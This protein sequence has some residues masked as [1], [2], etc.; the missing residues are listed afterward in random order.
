MV[1]GFTPIIGLAVVVALALAAVFGSM[2]LANPAQAAVGQPADAELTERVDSPQVVPASFTVS[3]VTGGATLSWTAAAATPAPTAWV[4][5]ITPGGGQTTA[6][7]VTSRVE[8]TPDTLGVFSG[9]LT[10]GTDL[11]TSTGASIGGLTNE[12][13]YCFTVQLVTASGSSA[14]T[15]SMCVTPGAMPGGT[16]TITAV[17]PG[18]GQVE[19]SWT[20]STPSGPAV[21][22]WQYGQRAN[23]ET[24]FSWKDLGDVELDGTTYKATVTGLMASGTTA[25]DFAVRPVSARGVAGAE[26][27]STGLA[28]GASGYT[29]TVGPTFEAQSQKPG[30]NTRYDITIPISLDTAATP[31]ETFSTVTDEIVVELEDYSVPP[32]IAETAV[33]VT[34]TRGEGAATACTDAATSCSTTTIV[35]SL[36]V[37]GEK[38]AITIGDWNKDRTGGNQASYTAVKDDDNITIVLKQSA[39]IKNPTKAGNYGPAIEVKATNDPSNK[40]VDIDMTDRH[41]IQRIVKLSEEDG[42]LGDTVMATASGFEKNVTVRFFIDGYDGRVPNGMLNQGEDIL[43]AATSGGDNVAS[44]EFTVSTPVFKSGDNYVNAR[45]GVGNVGTFQMHDDQK[46]TLKPSIKPTPAGGSPGEIIQVQLASFMQGAVTR[47][48][49]AGR[50]ICGGTSGQTCN[51]SVNN[52]GT[53]TTRVA[54]PNWAGSG[55]QELKVWVGSQDDKANVTIAGPRVVSTPSTVVANQRV[56]LIGTGFSPNARLGNITPNTDEI[57]PAISIGGATIDWNDVNDGRVVNVD[58][59]GNWSASVDLPMVEATTGEGERLIRITDSKGRTGAKNVTLAARDFT[60]TPPA[61]RVGTL[62]VVRGMGYPGK[63]DEGTSFT[64]DVTYKVSER[65]ET[66]VS[67]VPDAS[68]RFEVQL[69]IPTTAA[70]PSTNQVEVSFNLERNE[71]TI[72][73]VKQHMVPEGIINLSATSGGPG[74]TVTVSGE[75]F[76]N[77]APVAS[78]KIGAI[79]ITPAPNPHTDANGMM[80]FDVLIPGLDVG[81]Q[82][83]EVQVGGTTSSTGFTVIESGIAPGDI[84]PSAEAL[85]PLGENFDSVWHFNND[86][87]MWSFYDG[88]DGSD[89]EVMITGETYLI[90]IKSDA[91]GVI[92]NG[93]TR[94]LTC[95]DAGN[96]WNQIVW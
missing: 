85:E 6:L 75:G 22:K 24:D 82:T 59:S 37:S 14:P 66:R 60:I 54:I 10:G 73:D 89:L 84:K 11:I 96:C 70:I 19:L 5:N 15:D 29:I 39:G 63:N 91:I 4:V 36:S 53:G 71:G 46:F 23:G 57:P 74:S 79:D 49:L 1:R 81:I 58:D 90:L 12:T 67:V 64:I 44:C 16:T 61:G 95:N 41:T 62:A 87:K 76:K 7:R 93:K 86:T 30:S 38:I 26:D 69:R 51:G 48:S 72:T 13:E 33:A 32:S 20:Y 8:A 40:L 31:P 21:A 94:S 65:S 28:D 88:L 80:E 42:G 83:I 18:A 2:S 35:D 68:G 25:Q 78:V 3:A 47:V 45:D 27:D 43:C 52:Q 17:T 50:D 34:L 56:S 55:V 77:F 92:L 9:Y